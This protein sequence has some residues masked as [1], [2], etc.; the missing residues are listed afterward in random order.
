MYLFYSNHLLT[1]THLNFFMVHIS[2][3]WLLPAIKMV[4]LCP[5]PTRTN[6]PTFPSG[7]I[8]VWNRSTTPRKFNRSPLRMPRIPKR[9]RQTSSFPIIWKKGRAVKLRGVWHFFV[10]VAVEVAIPTSQIKNMHEKNSSFL[11]SLKCYSPKKL[12]RFSLNVF[13]LIDLQIPNSMESQ[14]ANG[15]SQRPQHRTRHF[16]TSWRR[17]SN[18]KSS[19]NRDENKTYLKPPPSMSTDN[20]PCLFKQ[21]NTKVLFSNLPVVALHSLRHIFFVGLNRST[22]TKISFSHVPPTVII[23][24]KTCFLPT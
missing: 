10:E 20:W 21:N 6:L 18:W 8:N 1:V 13:L 15:D 5:S 12:L 19:P 3:M 16:K 7:N 11:H 4:Q 24:W 9:K 23:Y 2:A 14:S 22:A 17:Y